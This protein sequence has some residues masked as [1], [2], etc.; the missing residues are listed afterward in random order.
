VHRDLLQWL[1]VFG[2][3]VLMHDHGVELWSGV[4]QIPALVVRRI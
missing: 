2:L 4:N 1:L 3:F